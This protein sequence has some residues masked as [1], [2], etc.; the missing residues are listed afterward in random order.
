M[1][2]GQHLG[3]DF[4]QS[5][6]FTRGWT[7]QELIAPKV[8]EFYS[9]D[10]LFLG[11]KLSLATAI[12]RITK[13]PEA[14]LKG[15]RLLYTCTV[16]ERMEWAQHRQ[17]KKEEDRIYSLIGIFDVSMSIIYGEGQ[18]KAMRRLEREIWNN[19]KLE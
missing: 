5:R 4:A 16:A 14:V 19:R 8:V 3:P 6:W 9:S 7:L 18:A 13:I 17:T 11:E 15:T 10:G 2:S 12:C 1:L